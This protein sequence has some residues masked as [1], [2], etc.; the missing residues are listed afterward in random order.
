MWTRGGSSPEVSQVSFDKSTDNGATWTPLGSGTRI[1]STSN[2][3]LTGLSL[4][5]SGQLRARGRTA[6]GYQNGSSSLVEQ[7]ASF[8]G[9]LP[10]L[11]TW[12]QTHFG[13]TANAGDAADTFDFDQDGLVNLIEFAFGLDPK[14]PSSSAQLP[15]PNLS[16]GNSMFNFTQ[17]DGVSG[18]TYGAEWSTTLLPGSW[19]SIPDNGISQQHVFSIPTAGQPKM[20]LR[21]VITAP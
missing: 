13:T 10:A 16:G 5:T 21:L 7:V 4:P 8:S 15:Q 12:R 20:Y 11:E 14:L 2:W 6:G 17:P 19:T 18:I 3:Q 1:G 9:L